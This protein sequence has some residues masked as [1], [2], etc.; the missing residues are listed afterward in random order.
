LRGIM[1]LRL[2]LTADAD[3]LGHKGKPK[4][5][6]DKI[7]ALDASQLKDKGILKVEYEGGEKVVLDSWKLQ[8]FRDLVALVEANSPVKPTT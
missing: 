2:V 6:W 5:P 1:A 4:R 8:N 3:G 7:T